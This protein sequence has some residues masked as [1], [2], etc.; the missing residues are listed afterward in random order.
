VVAFDLLP[1][2]VALSRSR[3]GDAGP[4]IV[5]AIGGFVVFH[6]MGRLV[7]REHRLSGAISALPLVAHSLV[8]GVG[9]GLAFQ[10]SPGAGIAVALAVIAH[11][12]CDGL[13]TVSLML[14]H[15]STRPQAITMLALDAF[16]PALGTC[17]AL[18]LDPE[19]AM[20]VLYLGFVGGL[21]LCVAL[22]DV[23][24][25]ARAHARRASAG[26]LVA[27]AMLGASSAAVVALAGG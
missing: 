9:I 7:G 24:P 25:L 19:P 2:G 21:L 15:R 6:G 22:A 12:F 14:A 4:A 13:S 27:L 11:D 20:L 5:A 26:G 18:A 3:F 23:L 10:V 17:A 8:D 16:A 1:E